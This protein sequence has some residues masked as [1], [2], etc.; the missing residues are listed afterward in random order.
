MIMNKLLGSGCTPI[1][2]R[3]IVRRVSVPGMIAAP[4]GTDR[5]PH[6]RRNSSTL[7]LVLLLQKVQHYLLHLGAQE[8]F[9]V[10]MTSVSILLLC[11]M[12]FL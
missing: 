7:G 5:S 4:N 2:P 8:E 3:I 12:S 9:C 10:W 11:M 1:A 6:P